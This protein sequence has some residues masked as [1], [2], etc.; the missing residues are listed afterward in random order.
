MIEVFL[1]SLQRISHVFIQPDVIDLGEGGHHLFEDLNLLLRNQL[2]HLAAWVS[3]IP[4]Y[5]GIRGAYLDTGRWET[6]VNP[7]N[8]KVALLEHA[9]DRI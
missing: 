5:H 3:Q 1:P 6:G 2:G 7:V 9:S 4:K 8:T